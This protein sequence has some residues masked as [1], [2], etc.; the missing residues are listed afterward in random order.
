MVRIARSGRTVCDV[1]GKSFGDSQNGK[2][3]RYRIDYGKACSSQE[4]WNSRQVRRKLLAMRT[5]AILVIAV[6]ILFAWTPLT[7]AENGSIVGRVFDPDGNPVSGARVRA[8]FTGSFDGIVPS[9]ISDAEGRFSIDHLNFGGYLVAADKEE[10]GYPR[11]DVPFYTGLNPL[12]N[13]NVAKVDLNSKYSRVEV[14]VRLARKGGTL[15]GTIRDAATGKPIEPCAEFRR[16]SA[17]D[18]LQ[19]GSVKP[20]YRLLIPAD[21]DLTMTVW[22]WGYQPF[23]YTDHAGKRILRIGEGEQLQLDIRLK[24]TRNS[25]PTGI[26][27]QKMR[28]SLEGSVCNAP[29][30]E[31]P[32]ME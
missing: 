11:Q 4:S 16:E 3:R 12:S 20:D 32:K 9:A 13:P 30:T 22:T 29:R 31:L 15:F 7:F 18:Y 28:E 17:G 2:G 6:A 8:N 21:A 5:I 24:P 25:T 1:K 27:L 26:E 19:L 23:F 10:A 14:T